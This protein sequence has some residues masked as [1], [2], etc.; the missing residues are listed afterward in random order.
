MTAGQRTLVTF[1]DRLV[2]YALVGAA[3]V[4]LLAGG[5]R[6]DGAAVRIAGDGGFER[7]AP[8]GS[9]RTVEVDGPLGTTVVGIA[10]GEARV[11][12]SPC[13]HQLCVKMG[14]VRTPG[15]TAVCVPN[16]VVVTVEGDGPAPT[17]AVTR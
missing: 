16:R 1:A 9:D 15:Q 12:S 14:A 13:P 10:G 3:V 6:G 8:L 5:G 7:L 17:D 11:L 4:L 2:L